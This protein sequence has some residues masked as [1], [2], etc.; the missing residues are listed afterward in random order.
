M[1]LL[2]L[3]SRLP[4]AILYFISD[5]LFFITFY[6]VRYRRKM[7]DKNLRNAFPE[8]DQG[9][10]KQIARQFYRNLCDYAVETLKLLTISREEISRRMV[11]KNTAVVSELLRQ[12][13]SVLQLTAHQFNWEWLLAHGSFVYGAPMDFVY[14]RVSNEF[15]NKVSF[16]IRTRFGAHPIL[17]DEVAR[18]SVRRKDIVRG[19]AIVADQYPGFSRDKKYQ[20]KFLN[21]ETVFFYGSNQ[22]AL[23][24]QYPVVFYSVKKIKRGCYETTAVEIAQPPFSKHEDVVIES[25]VRAVEKMIQED[26]AGWLWSHNRWKKRH[27]KPT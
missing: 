17:R 12:G 7:V 13:K 1:F 15:F 11:F 26:P 3:I 4:F 24:L 25:Y 23:M 5:V 2:R 22:L 10:R 9:T 27:L 19:I 16:Q 18:E 20:T 6:V 8:K 14:Q 21:Q